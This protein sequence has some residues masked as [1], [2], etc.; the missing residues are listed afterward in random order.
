MRCACTSGRVIQLKFIL[1]WCLLSRCARLKHANPASKT[2]DTQP[3]L[4]WRRDMDG[5][6]RAVFA[7][8]RWLPDLAPITGSS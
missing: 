7:D 5:R 6:L 1:A 4:R 3:V 2:C 8:T